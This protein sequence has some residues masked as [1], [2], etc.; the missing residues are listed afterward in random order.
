MAYGNW[1]RRLEFDPE[2]QKDDAAGIDFLAR[3][4]LVD[5]CGEETSFSTGILGPDGMTIMRV[6]T[7]MPIGFIHFPIKRD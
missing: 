6:L 5:N 2:K 4:L 7:P 1:A 3:I